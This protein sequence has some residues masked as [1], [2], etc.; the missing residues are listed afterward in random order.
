[1]L[2]LFISVQDKTSSI[3]FLDLLC[4][5]DMVAFTLAMGTGEQMGCSMVVEDLWFQDQFGIPNTV[6]GY[7]IRKKN[8][9]FM[10]YNIRKTFNYKSIKRQQRI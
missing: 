10:I 5:L 4:T 6:L 7:I 9:C 2:P 8:S 1:M 3:T